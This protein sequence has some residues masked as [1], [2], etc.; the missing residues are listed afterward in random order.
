MILFKAIKQTDKSKLSSTFIGQYGNDSSISELIQAAMG[1]IKVANQKR[2]NRSP[3]YWFSA[4]NDFYT[5]LRYLNAHRDDEY[6]YNGIARIELPNT[7]KVGYIYDFSLR[8]NG[9][10]E[11]KVIDNEVICEWKPNEDGIVWIL[12]MSSQ[13]TINYLA[14]LFWLKGNDTTFRDFRV[15]RTSNKDHE[16]LI[17]GENIKYSFIGVDTANKL[18]S[19]IRGANNYIDNWYT[20]LFWKFVSNAPESDL[21]TELLNKVQIKHFTA[22]EEYNEYL[23]DEIYWLRKNAIENDS[24]WGD[25]FLELDKKDLKRRFYL[26]RKDRQDRSIRCFYGLVEGRYSPERA[27][28]RFREFHKLNYEDKDIID[29]DKYEPVRKTKTI[30]F[31]GALTAYIYSGFNMYGVMQEQNLFVILAHLYHDRFTE[32]FNCKYWKFYRNFQLYIGMFSDGD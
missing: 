1:H 20:E 19:K 26:D 32:V 9:Y 2:E 22:E 31:Y 8:E 28:R 24:Y 15:L 18:M 5:A 16:F 10:L 21:K 3:D 29:F 25:D 6:G 14:S 13:A 30:S 11:K 23:F 12:D 7:D 27:R 4:T 17:L